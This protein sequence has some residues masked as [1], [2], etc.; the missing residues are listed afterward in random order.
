MRKGM[1]GGKKNS[2]KGLLLESLTM[3][4]SRRLGFQASVEK[5]KVF[6]DRCHIL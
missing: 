4:L 5:E 2:T 1:G 3:L 6:L